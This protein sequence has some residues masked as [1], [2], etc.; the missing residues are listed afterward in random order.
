MRKTVTAAALGVAFAFTGA[1]GAS[2][3]PPDAEILSGVECDN[4]QTY[5]V[6]VNGNGD[7]TPGHV[8]DSTTVFVPISFGDVAFTVVTPDGAVTE[9]EEEHTLAK[10]QGKVA[11]HNPREAVSCTFS[12]TFVLE[13]E[14]M[15]FPAGSEVTFTGTVVGYVSGR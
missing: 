13:V 1:A 15:G 6:W 4:G 5:D 14:E 9:I 8:V 10:G 11:T 7:F 2:A 3:A 12:E